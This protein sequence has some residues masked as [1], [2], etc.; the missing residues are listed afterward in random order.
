MPWN[1]L[2]AASTNESLKQY[3]SDLKVRMDHLRIL[4]NYRFRGSR[5]RG[6]SRVE[7]G[8]GKFCLSNKVPGDADATGP[9]TA[10]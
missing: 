1:L 7:G 8:E 6:G 4:V 5:G 9:R 10:L 3:F 2:T